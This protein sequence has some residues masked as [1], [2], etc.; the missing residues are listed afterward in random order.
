MKSPFKN[1]NDAGRPALPLAELG[2]FAAV[3]DA[4]GFSAAARR[5]DVSK[6]MVST[7]ISRLEARLGVRLFQRTTRRLSLTE[8]GTAALEPARRALAAA[9][10]AEEAATRQRATPRGTLRLS[11]PM[12][13]GLLHVAPALSAFAAR[14]P[15]VRVDLVLDD[16]FA[17]LVQGGFDLAVRIGTLPDSTL[18]AQRISR[19]RNVLVAS[20]RHLERAGTPRTAKDLER[21]AVLVYS[22]TPTANAWTL[23]SG[24][25]QQTVH[26][27]GPLQA[28]NSLAL[29][30]AA[31]QGLGI[32]RLPLFVAA[33]ELAS[34]KLVRVLPD[35]ELPEQGIFCV[36]TSRE[37]QPRKTRA[38][39][40]F[41]RERLGDPPYWEK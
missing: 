22:V 11:A 5:L 9:Q 30:E 36:T 2:V 21:H 19:N 15:D 33:A 26:V 18:V 32:A 4:Q 14:Y 13:F 6:A 8:A 1:A 25:K 41:L 24:K 28:N 17:D 20:R 37:H 27:A 35:W 29:K 12:S 31:L 38:F 10:E 23:R 40:E 39:I 3:A 16:R 7:A 34:K